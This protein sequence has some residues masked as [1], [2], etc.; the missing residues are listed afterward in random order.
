MKITHLL[1]A[2]AAGTLLQAED[3]SIEKCESVKNWRTVRPVGKSAKTPTVRFVS[4]EKALEFRFP[5]ITA[6]RFGTVPLDPAWKLDKKFT[7]LVFKVKGDG[8][9][10]WGTITVSGGPMKENSFYFPVKNTEW[11]EYRV[12][13]AA[14]APAGDH[15]LNFS[16]L[17]AGEICAVSVGD[18]WR[19]REGNEPRRPFSCMI[20]D[21][22]VTDDEF[23]T[24]PRF[25]PAKLETA[26]AAMKS[27]K[28][29]TIL[30]VGDSIT[31]GTGLKNRAE[32][33]YGA[34]LQ[35]ILRKHFNNN[36]INV[37]VA[38]V[39][40]AHT[41]DSLGWLERDLAGETPDVVTMLIG[42]NNRS[43][44]QSAEMYAKQLQLWIDRLCAA[45]AGKSAVVLIPT[46][47]GVPRFFSQTDMA[48]ATRKVAQAN[49]L[50]VADIDKW[51][52]SQKPEAYR[53]QY[54]R[55]S[56]HPNPAGHVRFAEILAKVFT[57]K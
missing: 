27:G 49:G 24:P 20:K 43:G 28:T 53:T 14:M 16:S 37:R 47:P 15:T 18:R 39:G 48:E 7:G 36:E 56:V 32:E 4:A 25:A 1:L 45:T 33:R 34:Q 51:I 26:V 44:H 8:S 9:D 50:A 13:F 21:I 41:S 17:E 10:D 40:G 6:R 11:K 54:L 38:A 30:C 42:F 5:S 29:V 12:P 57:G 22:R 2:L 3:F 55:D 19:I 31:A 35:K 52:L 23:P 46:V